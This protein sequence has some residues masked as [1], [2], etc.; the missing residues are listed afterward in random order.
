MDKR[1]LIALTLS[2][3]VMIVWTT[4]ISDKQRKDIPPPPEQTTTA[5]DSTEKDKATA[6]EIEQPQKEIITP[7]D[8]KQPLA[9][10]EIVVENNFYKAV[11]TTKGGTIKSF[12]LKEYF[13]IKENDDEEGEPRKIPLSL[14]SPDAAIKPMSLILKGYS[15]SSTEGF[16]YSADK[17]KVLL[18]KAGEED[19]LSFYYKNESG[20][21]IKKTFTFYK[22]DYKIGLSTQVKGVDSY[23][24][25]L[26]SDFGIAEQEG[27]WVHIGPTLLVDSKKIDIDKN[28]I[29]GIGFIKKLTGTKSRKETE[30]RGNIKWIAQEGKYFTSALVSR[31]DANVVKVW[32]WDDE[33]KQGAEIAFKVD[34]GKGDF[35]LYAG[36]KHYET[37]EAQGLGLEHIIDFGFF[38]I[39][40]RPLFWFLKYLYKFIGNYGWAIVILTI[41]VRVPFIPLLNKSQKSM[42]KMQKIQP[43]MA[44]LKEKYKKDQQKLQKE[45]MVIYKKHKVNPVGGCLPMLIQLPVF[46][47]LYKT[48]LVAIE[49]R[50]APFILWITDLSVKDPFYVFPIAMGLTMVLQQKMTP[51]AM[52]PKQAKMM[53][54]M[55]IVF[56]FMFL[57]FPAGLV[58]Y[59][60]VNNVL[61][62]IQQFFVN[63]QPS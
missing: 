54:L 45:M 31:N 35:L 24:V 18:D 38:S 40:S 52:D 8:L 55:P 59:W 23:R 17:D 53:M 4:L 14:I 10:K 46:F 22:D 39:I 13:E 21:I 43:L 28:N 47:A 51:S 56:T 1:T 25:T 16:N 29:E 5:K 9:E 36:P 12:K 58:I 15:K 33:G 30:H 32:T 7:D 44:E 11:F 63:R 48:L 57:S 50:Q 61:G 62:I 6:E 27:A 2:I 42:K 26:G 20:L 37:L 60:L 49:L 19:S 34:G 41:V 3:L